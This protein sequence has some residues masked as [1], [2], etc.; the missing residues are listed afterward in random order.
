MRQDFPLEEEDYG[1]GRQALA[2]GD[3]MI[4]IDAN[5]FAAIVGMLVAL[6]VYEIGMDL[7]GW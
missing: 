6:C 3:A 5:V 1:R 4:S 2:V 7:F